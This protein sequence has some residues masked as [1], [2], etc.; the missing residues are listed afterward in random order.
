[1]VLAL[2]RLRLEGP[3]MRRLLPLLLL[4]PLVPDA[5]PIER[6]WLTHQSGSPTHLV[7]NWETAQTAP[8]VVEYGA[9][10]A[11][12]SVASAPAEKIHHV[13][14][15][16][17]PGDLQVYYRVRSGDEI[18]A[19]HAFKGYPSDELRIAVIADTG[20]AK[21]SWGEAILR[22]N[23][24]LLIS[25]G[26]HVAALHRGQPV[27]PLDT[28]AFS[29]LVDGHPELFRRTP[30]LPLLGNHDRE[31]RPRG[32]RPPAEAVYDVEAKAFRRFFALPDEGWKWRFDLPAFGLR[33]LALDL[34]HTSDHGTTWQS[35]H[36]FLPGS[37]QFAWFREQ[38]E[39]SDQPFLIPLYNEKH[40]TVRGL[41]GGAYARLLARSNLVITGY[42]YFAERAEVGDTAF[43]NTSVSGAGTPYKDP[44]SVFLRSEDNFMLITV[45]PGR[46]TAQL[47]RIP[48]GS[49]LDEK[50]FAPRTGR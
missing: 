49:V 3:P 9:T 38:M 47:R 2:P 40:S 34:S 28:S 6:I 8:S 37:P 18:S 4:L 14:I 42:G 33:M 32:P 43:Y 23:P 31:I 17:R 27:D 7:V 21:T 22:T 39:N 5:A 50:S 48:D 44:R 20:Y 25:A 24:H 26:D 36:D 13:E 11:L 12:G 15:P 19:I 45:K 29:A 41:G 1:M 16:L 35:N 10:P 30:W 46:L